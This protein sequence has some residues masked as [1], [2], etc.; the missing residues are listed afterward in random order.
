LRSSGAFIKQGDVVLELSQRT[1]SDDAH[2]V[3]RCLA[4]D[5]AALLTLREQQYNR[6]VS[7]IIKRGAT[8]TEAS[9]LVADV[10]GELTTSRAG[11]PPLL[12]KYFAKC[13]LSAWLITVA[14]R[15][16]IDL[17]RRGRLF[18]DL[19]GDVTEKLQNELS[20]P[21]D[22]ALPPD[23]DLQDIL[24]R[25]VAESFQ[26]CTPET[27]VMLKL[28]YLHR[29]SQ[30]DIGRLWDWHESKVSRHMD[31]ALTDIHHSLLDRIK[32]RDGFL[33]VHWEDFIDLCESTTDLFNL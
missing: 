13:P 6:L 8:P 29:V 9:D 20:H 5:D 2:L 25:A 4:G 28:I 3:R 21:G 10:W 17:R 31:R 32:N 16:F 18:A 24:R 27:L 12:E 14:T 23:G 26:A 30:R 7:I 1:E 33:D 19:P 15:R 22:T 11:K